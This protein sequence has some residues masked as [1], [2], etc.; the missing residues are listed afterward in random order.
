MRCFSM[1]VFVA[2]FCDSFVSGAMIK[3]GEQ[4][5]LNR[6]LRF[7][8]DEGDLELVKELVGKGAEINQYS[9]YNHPVPPGGPTLDEG[10][11]HRHY[12]TQPLCEAVEKGRTAVVKWLVEHSAD[13]NGRSGICGEPPLERAAWCNKAELID[14]LIEH[15]ADVNY[16]SKYGI[17]ALMSAA[18]AGRLPIFLKL[19]TLYDADPHLMDSCGRSALW[20]LFEGAAYRGWNEDRE[21]MLKFLLKEKVN[22]NVHNTHKKTPLHFAASMDLQACQLLVQAKAAVNIRDEDKW[23]PLDRAVYGYKR[24]RDRTMYD[25]LVECGADEHAKGNWGA[26]PAQQMKKLSRSK[27]GEE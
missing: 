11:L 7:A 25:Y 15:K 23:T 4:A 2:L 16:G 20:H 12:E 22:P 10:E 26:T 17:T 3:E 5:V 1:V 21:C 6:D 24:L 8:A 19:F 27:K 14:Y 18:N 13:V 9:I